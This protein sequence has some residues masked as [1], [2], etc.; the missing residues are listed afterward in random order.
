MF[1]LC[2]GRGNVIF[3]ACSEVLFWYSS[4]H[5][6]PLLTRVWIF[7]FFIHALSY[8]TKDFPWSHERQGAA[9]NSKARPVFLALPPW[10]ISL[11]T[12]YCSQ[13]WTPAACLCFCRSYIN[14][15]KFCTLYVFYH[16]SAYLTF[17]QNTSHSNAASC[18]LQFLHCIWKNITLKSKCF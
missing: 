10:T 4:D 1:R 17:I 6:Y 3:E 9:A 18:S 16:V 15:C 14:T 11:F 13:M 8:A 2:N 12:L 7:F 5:V